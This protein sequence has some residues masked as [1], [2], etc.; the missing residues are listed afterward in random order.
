MHRCTCLLCC[1]LKSL[2]GGGSQSFSSYLTVHE[3]A[4]RLGLR[5]SWIYERQKSLP[6]VVRVSPRRLRVDAV[7]LQAWIDAGGCD[8]GCTT[9]ERKTQVGRRG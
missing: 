8:G 1:A 7:K 2:F 4:K 9:R 6:W 5:P 3:A